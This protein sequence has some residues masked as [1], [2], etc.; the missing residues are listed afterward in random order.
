MKAETRNVGPSAGKP[1]VHSRTQ[2]ARTTTPEVGQA[3][4][5]K[6]PPPTAAQTQAQQRADTERRK[7]PAAPA[8][9]GTAMVP[10]APAPTAEER[11]QLI[12][13]NIAKLGGRGAAASVSFHGVDGV[14]V[15]SD[16]TNLPIGTLA[17]FGVPNFRIG[18]CNFRNGGYEEE[19]RGIDEV[20]VER[21]DL[22][23]GFD[24][25]PGMSGEPRL[26]WQEQS[27][28][29]VIL[30][31]GGH[32]MLTLVCRNSVSRIALDGLVS[33]CYGHPLF[34]RGLLPIVEM[35]T[36][37]YIN[38]KLG[39]VKKPKPIFRVAGWVNTDGS[40]ADARLAAPQQGDRITSGKSLPA[41]MGDEIPFE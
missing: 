30:T 37:I 21:S 25:E 22:D 20:Q 38:K 27:T 9:D 39:G 31:E 3:T 29:P 12:A 13:H 5:S 40:P 32:E 18:F 14:Y 7:Q 34:K 17:V 8:N 11:A 4:P 2:A 15:R 28:M 35:R 26:V 41:E 1:D 6:V 24:T 33:N 23:G 16:D 10:A 19:M 36:G